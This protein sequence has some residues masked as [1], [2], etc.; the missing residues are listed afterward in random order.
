MTISRAIRRSAGCAWLVPL[1]LVASGC[2]ADGGY[3][4]PPAVSVGVGLDYYEP[5]GFDYGGWGPAYRVGPPREGMRRPESGLG[6]GYRLAP[7][8]RA[9]PSIPTIPRADGGR[10]GTGARR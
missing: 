2:V 8:G 3:A 10:L 6:H 4:Y 9:L 7:T 5:F 1:L